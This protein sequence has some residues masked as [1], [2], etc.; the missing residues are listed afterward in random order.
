MGIWRGAHWIGDLIT[1]L[2][3]CP[4]S[5]NR[6]EVGGNVLHTFF[7]PNSCCADYVDPIKRA[8]HPLLLFTQSDPPIYQNLLE[9]PFHSS[10]VDF[11]NLCRRHDDTDLA[12]LAC[13]PSS[14]FLRLFH[15][16]LPWYFDIYQVH[17]NGI[18]V[19]DILQQI[20]HQ[21]HTQ[22]RL[23]DFYNEAL[24]DSERAEIRR[25]FQSR[26]R[27][28]QAL[29]SKGA[30]RIDY[31]GD[32]IVFEGLLRGHKGLWELKLSRERF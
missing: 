30:L 27:N 25:A 20:H 2:E 16:R 7:H 17:P 22:I 29:I 12:Q 6:T 18:T 23:R 4:L 5:K 21:L 31:L 11:L 15:P 9:T 14:A 10:S 8:L 19:G 13:Q 24:T 26:C 28:N 1:S 3:S 32:K